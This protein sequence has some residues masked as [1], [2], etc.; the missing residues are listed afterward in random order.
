[1]PDHATPCAVATHTSDPVPYL[2][3]DSEHPGAGGKYSE[4][5]VADRAVVPAHELMQRLI[6]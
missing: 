2:L 1:M 6:G 5:G 4:S 3:Y